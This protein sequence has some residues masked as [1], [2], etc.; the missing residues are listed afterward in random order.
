MET[1][2]KRYRATE[3]KYKGGATEMYVTYDL[4]LKT[5][6]DNTA[7]F[8][9]VKRVYIA[10]DVKGWKKGTF[11]KRS[12]RE[13]YGILVEYEQDRQGYA[14]GPYNAQRGKRNYTVPPTTVAA[15]SQRFKQV[16]EIPEKAVN[17]NF[18]TEAEKLPEQYRH[19][20]QGVR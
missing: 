18:Y 15:S 17:I 3:S 4:E 5:R 11:K 20:L 8:P 2:T 14:R 13:V 9:K 12:G 16:V 19:A 6:N 1:T 7:L 10:G